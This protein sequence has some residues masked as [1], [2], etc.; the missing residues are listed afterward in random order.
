MTIRHIVLCGGGYNGI[1]TIGA[2]DYLLRQ[3]FFNI[4]DIKTIYGTSV[5]GFIGVLLCLKLPWDTILDYIIERPWERD[6]IFSADMMFNMIPK[7]GLLD[8]SYM[9][10]FFT[11][12][13]KAKK[14][15]PEITLSEFNIF[16]NIDLF[17]FAVDVNAFDVVKISHH[18]HPDLK[19]IDAIFITCSIPFIFQP[20]FIEKTYLVDG[21]VLCNY[22]LDYCINDGADKEEILGVQFHLNKNTMSIDQTTNIL[23]Y[24]YYMFDKLVGVA[25]KDPINNIRNEVIVP[26]D[27][28]NISVGVKI[29][30]D[31]D[32]RLSYINKGR[33]CAKLFISYQSKVPCLK[34]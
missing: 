23:Y 17:I 10:L 31:K 16:S 6:M 29:I 34:S 32:L 28:M 13:L 7:K 24:G 21:G 18:S 25:R 5:G 30:N 8:S 12:L 14:L 3:Q 15:S 9:K 22:P 1:Y 19:L 4:D 27:A 33:E 11:K 26:C 2:I 20:T